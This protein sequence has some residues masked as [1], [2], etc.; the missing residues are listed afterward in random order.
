MRARDTKNIS[1][2]AATGRIHDACLRYGVGVSTMRRLAAEAN[3]VI[4]IGRIYLVNYEK[5]DDY[6][7]SISA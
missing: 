4:R 7:K 3:A 1:P 2:V 5:M 6:M